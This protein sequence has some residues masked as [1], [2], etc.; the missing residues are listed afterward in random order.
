MLSKHDEWKL[1][2]GEDP[3]WLNAFESACDEAEA[4][5]RTVKRELGHTLS[6]YVDE[7]SDGTVKVKGRLDFEYVHE[8]VK[9]GCDLALQNVSNAVCKPVMEMKEVEA[10]PGARL[11]RWFNNLFGRA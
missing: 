5:E 3:K 1:D 6:L 9:V 7:C 8:S 4:I 2:N 11:V 10:A